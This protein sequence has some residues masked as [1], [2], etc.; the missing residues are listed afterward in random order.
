MLWDVV[1]WGGEGECPWTEP[2]GLEGA[3]GVRT[4][5]LKEARIEDRM[6]SCSLDGCLTR[7]VG[8]RP[9]T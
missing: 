5:E 7:G 1:D 4:E 3:R 6:S 9:E 8:F 2:L